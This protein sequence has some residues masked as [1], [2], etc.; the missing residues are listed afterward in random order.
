M[1]DSL[2]GIYIY[3]CVCVNS[4]EYKTS[5]DGLTLPVFTGRRTIQI[6]KDGNL[7][8]RIEQAFKKRR[9]NKEEKRVRKR[10]EIRSEEF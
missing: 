7:A 6:E 3:V 8:E 1:Y 9:L 2:I 10:R 5:T 4:I